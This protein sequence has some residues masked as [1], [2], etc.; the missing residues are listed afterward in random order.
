VGANS[1]VSV[2]VGL[3][4]VSVTGKLTPETE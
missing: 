3:V 4:E 1:T 2:A